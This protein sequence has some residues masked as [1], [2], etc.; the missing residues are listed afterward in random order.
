M[1]P[2]VLSDSSVLQDRLAHR[3][4]NDADIVLNEAERLLELSAADESRQ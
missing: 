2:L 3:T 4:P 1:P